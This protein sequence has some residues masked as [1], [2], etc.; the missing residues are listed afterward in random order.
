M[1]VVLAGLRIVPCHSPGDLFGGEVGI[2]ATHRIELADHQWD[3]L[4]AHL[5]KMVEVPVAE[6]E[7][8][9]PLHHRRAGNL[10]APPLVNG[11]VVEDALVEGEDVAALAGAAEDPRLHHRLHLGPLRR[12]GVEGEDAQF[13]AVPLRLFHAEFHQFGQAAVARHPGRGRFVDDFPVVHH[14]PALEFRADGDFV[15]DQLDQ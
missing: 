9:G 10:V 1:V 14:S 3:H 5:Q 7:G 15:Q 8:T 13:Q 12:P 2:G 4:T 6:A 11:P